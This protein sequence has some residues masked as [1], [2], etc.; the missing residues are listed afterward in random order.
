VAVACS[1]SPTVDMFRPECARAG[2]R[3]RRGLT[4]IQSRRAACGMASRRRN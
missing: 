4:A 1:L 2:R 3:H